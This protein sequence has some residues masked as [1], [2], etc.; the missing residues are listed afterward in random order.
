[1]TLILIARVNL[2][3]KEIPQ[4]RVVLQ[5]IIIICLGKDRNELF[6]QQYIHEDIMKTFL[7]VS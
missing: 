7:R 1:M 5:N 6:L 4:C 3:V 2:Y